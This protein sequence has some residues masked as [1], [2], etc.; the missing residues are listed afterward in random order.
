MNKI[1]YTPKGSD[2]EYTID[3]QYFRALAAKDILA[4]IIDLKG[5]LTISNEVGLAV[6]YAD[7]LIKRLKI[8]ENEQSTISKR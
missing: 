6:K 1:I 3:W 7:E 2:V 8:E 4:H 5:G